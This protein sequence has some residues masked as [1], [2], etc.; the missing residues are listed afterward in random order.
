MVLIKLTFAD[1]SGSVYVNM[2]NVTTFTA[3]EN[4]TKIS[5]CGAGSDDS[6]FVV[7]SETLADVAYHAELKLIQLTAPGFRSTT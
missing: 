3:L 6:S 2:D 4:N 1:G 7:V 5:F